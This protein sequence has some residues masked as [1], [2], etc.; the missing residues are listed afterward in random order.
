VEIPFLDFLFDTSV[1]VKTVYGKVLSLK[2]K[3][4]TKPGTKFKL[5]GKGRTSGGKT[6]DMFVIVNAKMPH[7]PDQKILKMID[8]IRD[9]I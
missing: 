8:G 4:N 1:S 5:T 2:L 7:A 9:S 6:G 3:A